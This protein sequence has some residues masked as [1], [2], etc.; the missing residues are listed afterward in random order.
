MLAVDHCLVPSVFPLLHTASHSSLAQQ[1]L[2]LTLASQHL[3]INT[4]WIFRNPFSADGIIF[5]I[6]TYT[7]LVGGRWPLTPVGSALSF[8]PRGSFSCPRFHL[9]G[10]GGPI[11][12]A[13]RGLWLWLSAVQ[14]QI[15][16][17][18]TA[19]FLVSVL[20]DQLLI[21]SRYYLLFLHNFFFS[22]WHI[23]KIKKDEMK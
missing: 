17:W 15:I 20:L 9:V 4:G 1:T 2:S 18:W 10:S 8:F 11:V 22:P 6:S 19:L 5:I 23:F 21:L 7:H 12:W 3:E 16:D 14:I 13:V